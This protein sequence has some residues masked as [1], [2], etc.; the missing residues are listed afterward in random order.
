MRA[1][2]HEGVGEGRGKIVAKIAEWVAVAVVVLSSHEWITLFDSMLTET[3][4]AYLEMEETRD[5]PT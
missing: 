5:C 1:Q 4:S 2:Y 3:D